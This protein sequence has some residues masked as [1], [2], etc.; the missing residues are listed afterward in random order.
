MTGF[1]A[2]RQVRQA[3]ANMLVV[4][5]FVECPDRFHARLVDFDGCLL[6]GN[7]KR[8]SNSTNRPGQLQSFQS[9]LE[10]HGGFG[11]IDSDHEVDEV[12]QPGSQRLHL[13]REPF[14]LRQVLM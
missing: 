10:S 14:L 13:V 3:F 6:E 2:S 4:G 11:L 9:S 1:A 5:D 7:F 12:P 8:L